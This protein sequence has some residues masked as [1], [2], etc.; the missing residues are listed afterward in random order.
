MDT[1][2]GC[3]AKYLVVFGA[4]MVGTSKAARQGIQV[5]MSRLHE[6]VEDD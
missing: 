4:S 1:D 6:L 3:G 5:I 2:F